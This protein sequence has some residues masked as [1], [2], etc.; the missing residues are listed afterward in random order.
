MSTSD[1]AR[2]EFP[3]LPRGAISGLAFSPDG[4]QLGMTV[5]SPTTPGDVFSLDLASH[6]V[7][8]WTMSETGGFTE[9]AFVEPALIRFETFDMVDGASRTI[10]AFY[11][12]P[13][14]DGPFPVVLDIHGGPESQERPT[15][16]SWIQYLVNEL[17]VAVLAPNVRGSNGYGKSY[18]LLDNGVRR[19]DSVRDIGALLDWVGK[20]PELSADRVAV[21]RRVDARL[22]RQFRPVGC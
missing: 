7:T 10:P 21:Y 9:D 1:G 13:E 20:Q 11:Y 22:N 4:T 8:R 6:E 3:P 18:L 14:G 15:F 2:L 5:N 16:N 17:G 12:R 19:E